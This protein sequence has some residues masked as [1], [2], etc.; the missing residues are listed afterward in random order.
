MSD[1][2]CDWCHGPIPATARRDAETCSTRCRQ[3]RHRY[4]RGVGTTTQPA[5]DQLTPLR[6]AYADPPYPGNSARYYRHHPDYAG[7]VDHQALIRYLAE[8]FNGWALS[9]AASSLP[10]I[11]PMCPPGIR[12]AAWVRGARH[13]RGRRWPAAAWEPVI[14]QPGRTMTAARLINGSTRDPV[15]VLVHNARPRTTDPRRVIGAKPAAFAGWIFHLLG[16]TPADDFHDVFP[17]SGGMSRAWS[18]WTGD[19]P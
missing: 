14:Y 2:I 8:N 12:V 6:L 16:A 17:G 15:D 1:R 7:E 19:Q 3:A 9:T 11:L 13:G 10:E 4:R 5:R 18:I